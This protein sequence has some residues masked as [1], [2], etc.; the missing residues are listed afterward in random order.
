MEQCLKIYVG[1]GTA[2]LYCYS[3][4]FYAKA[5]PGGRQKGKT[6]DQSCTCV[7]YVESS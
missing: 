2:L 6:K 4:H 3:K 5:N 7:V 1:T